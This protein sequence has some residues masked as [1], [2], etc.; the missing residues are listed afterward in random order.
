M[1]ISMYEIAIFIFFYKAEILGTICI[2][3]SYKNLEAPLTIKK[4]CET[5]NNFMITNFF[6]FLAD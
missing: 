2:N 4:N 1:K 3:S 6:F 5:E